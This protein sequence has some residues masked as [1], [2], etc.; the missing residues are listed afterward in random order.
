MHTNYELHPYPWGSGSRDKHC[1]LHT[2]TSS[3]LRAVCSDQKPPFCSELTPFS[4]PLLWR[5]PSPA[6][7]SAAGLSG[8]LFWERVQPL[9]T[10]QLS[11]MQQS[12]VFPAPLCLQ[13]VLPD[14]SREG[15][16]PQGQ[17][18]EAESTPPLPRPLPSPQELVP[19]ASNS[20]CPHPVPT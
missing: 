8:D 3:A 1:I 20:P 7:W 19:V 2:L 11:N 13:G 17:G 12:Q 10:P 6:P 14:H 9:C 16:G 5:R 4:R 15:F 18:L